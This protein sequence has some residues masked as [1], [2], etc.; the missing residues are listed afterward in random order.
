[1]ARLLLVEDDLRISSPLKRSLE[2]DTHVVDVVDNGMTA[3]DFLT[4]EEYEV[5]LLDLNLPG[6]D[7]LSL[8]RRM[9]EKGITS[10]VLMLT[11]RDTDLDTVAGLDAG[12][13]DYVV[14]PFEVSV[15][16]ARIRSLL[17]RPSAFLPS[18]LQI[19]DLTVDL[20]SA[21]VTCLERLLPLTAREYSVLEL[22]ARNPGKTFSKDDLV[23]KLWGWDAPESDVVKTHVR[24]L[25]RKISLAGGRDPIETLYGFGYRIKSGN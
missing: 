7:G 21:T 19:L 10:A 9:R 18:E 6:L 12:A 11:A 22:L 23:E 5:V 15:L 1:M 2:R 4:T 25:R 3:W 20:N 8:C 16:K 17:R 24:S 13:D 14:K